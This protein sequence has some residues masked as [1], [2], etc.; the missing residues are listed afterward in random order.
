M[1]G[2]T[3]VVW[4]ATTATGF[5]LW[6]LFSG[7][8]DTAEIAVG[9][10]AALIGVIAFALVR[11]SRLAKFRPRPW[12]IVSSIGVVPDIVTGLWVLVVAL[13]RTLR[14]RP[15]EAYLHETR[16]MAGG[17]DPESA[18]RRALVVLVSTMTPSSIVIDVDRLRG[19]LLVHKL[20]KGSPLPSLAEVLGARE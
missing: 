3:I 10:T 5:L 14:G 13:W 1:P 18:A 20:M 19:T 15:S 8:L 16:F 11:S 17:D 6:W 4:V 12:W 9:A 7:E 2:R